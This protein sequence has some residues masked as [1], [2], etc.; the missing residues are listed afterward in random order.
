MYI[1]QKII[2][3]ILR[4]KGRYIFGRKIRV[5][6]NFTVVNP[7]NVTVGNNCAINHDVFIL[8][9]NRIEIGSNVVLSSRCMLIDSGLDL[10]NFS[11]EVNPSHISSFIRIEDGVWICAGS[12]IL[13]GVTLGKKCVVGAG[14]VVVHD[15]PAFTIVAGNP[16][17]VIGR[18]DG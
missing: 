3:I 16:A 11:S 15:V 9:A 4:I 13:P 5:Y 10:F 7:S 17:R 6:G 12:I 18:T 14:S 1:I 2:N 8:G